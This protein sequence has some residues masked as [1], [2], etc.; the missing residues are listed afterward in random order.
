MLYHFCSVSFLPLRLIFTNLPVLYTVQPITMLPFKY[1]PIL[2]FYVTLT[3]LSPHSF[4][5]SS[6]L[7][8]IPTNH[9]FI[10]PSLSCSSVLS[11]IT[12]HLSLF[13]SSH[14]S[15]IFISN[16]KKQNDTLAMQITITV[17][18]Q[19]NRMPLLMDV[20]ETLLTLKEKISKRINTPAS[21]ISV[22]YNNRYLT[23][24]K[25]TIKE[26]KIEN[27]AVVYLKRRRREVE[28]GQKSD[29]TEQMLKNPM[30]KNMLKNPEVMKGMLESFPG[31][32]KQINKNPELKMIM[33]NPN[34]IEEFEKLADNPDY[35]SQQLKNVDIAMSKLENI[36][37][38]FNMMNSMI[39]DVRDPLTGLIAQNN[40]V[41]VCAGNQE[42][43]RKVIPNVWKKKKS[44]NF[45][46]KYRREISEIRKYGF[47]NI[48][49]IAS[50]LGKCGGDVDG[51]IDV[52][53]K[54]Q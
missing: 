38:G 26:L 44:E 20:H 40:G 45:F 15:T 11:P 31:L 14:W 7:I 51:A 10:K 1:V 48:N 49:D 52:L 32:K 54:N 39:K 34:A 3:F 6:T 53:F 36:P 2:I 42:V 46:V 21:D 41:S 9:H 37:G 28:P 43:Q 47:D 50:A 23:D 16:Q 22:Y 30:V 33:N 25:K 12:A 18:F 29:M 17:Q 8:L 13:S 24:D 5:F 35:M 19:N 4:S 27:N